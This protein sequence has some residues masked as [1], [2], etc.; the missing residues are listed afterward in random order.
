MKTA[1]S[2]PDALF[3]QA[4]ETAAR[5]GLN[6]SQ[7]Y[8]KA[9]ETF[10]IQQGPDPVT[11]SLNAIADKYDCDPELDALLDASHSDARRLIDSGE[12]EW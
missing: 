9:L 2:L 8:A 7:L 6:R 1:V 11:E 10:I 12:W 5:L 3:D 4:E